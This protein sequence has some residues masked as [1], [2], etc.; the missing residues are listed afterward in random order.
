MIK[1]KIMLALAALTLFGCSVRHTARLTLHYFPVGAETLTAVT[2]ENITKRSR[3]CVIESSE[4]AERITTL[5]DSGA[6][7][8][9]NKFGDFAVRLR[10]DVERRDKSKAIYFMD[11]DGNV[12]GAPAGLHR[13]SEDSLKHLVE[14]I[15]RRCS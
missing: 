3:P 1:T 6:P 12:K 4:D 5:L 14:V 11:N 2:S 7:A 10:A 15:E 13:L 8:Q 9:G